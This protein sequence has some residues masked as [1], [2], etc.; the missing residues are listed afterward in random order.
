LAARGSPNKVI[1]HELN[2]SAWTVNTH[3]RRIFAKLNVTSRTAMVARYLEAQ[4]QL[5]SC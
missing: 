2:I 5:P 4:S 1:A 3:M